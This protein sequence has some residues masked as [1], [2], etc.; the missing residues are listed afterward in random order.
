MTAAIV[1]SDVHSAA[2]A[3][4]RA[5]DAIEYRP[6]HEAIFIKPNVPDYAPSGQGFFTDPAVVE[7]LLRYF[8]GRPIVIGEGSIAGRSTM[9]AFERTGSAGYARRPGFR[10]VPGCPPDPAEIARRF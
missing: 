10:L 9:K 6:T 4:A 7:G 8:A 3:V 5:L 2:E 1:R